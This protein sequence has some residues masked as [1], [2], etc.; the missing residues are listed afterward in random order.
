MYVGEVKVGSSWVDQERILFGLYKGEGKET[1][2]TG[3]LD[4][5]E[6]TEK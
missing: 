4:L 6:R 5:T 2:A 3:E 1:S